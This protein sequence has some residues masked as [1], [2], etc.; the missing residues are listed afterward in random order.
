MCKLTVLIPCL[1]EVKTISDV[2]SRLIRFYPNLNIVVIDN[3]SNDGSVEIIK[4]FNVTLIHEPIR[5]KTRAIK[6]GLKYITSEFVLLLDSDDEYDILSIGP[7]VEQLQVSTPNS[8]IIGNRLKNRMLLSSR[9]ANFVIRT[10]LY[11]R[12][13]EVI[14]DC[15]TGL[16]IV[17]TSLLKLVTSHGFELETEL[18]VLCLRN[19]FKIVPVDISYFPRTY[20]KK[21]KSTDM[22]RLLKVAYQ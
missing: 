19:N 22:I 11:I 9:V 20:G 17:P 15:L 14:P 12:Y 4:K 1:N 13:H 18:N 16:R 2:L 8:M 6:A 5:G 3:G 10:C 21:I 7:L